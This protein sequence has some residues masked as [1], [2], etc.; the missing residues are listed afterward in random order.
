MTSSESRVLFARIASIKVLWIFSEA[1]VF[2][3]TYV[4]TDMKDI[5]A[6]HNSRSWVQYGF[7]TKQRVVE[8]TGSLL[9]SA[10]AALDPE[11]CI[12]LCGW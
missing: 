6:G 11:E 3:Y 12:S 9:T 10:H 1:S 8:S 4:T 2:F 5:E 7:I